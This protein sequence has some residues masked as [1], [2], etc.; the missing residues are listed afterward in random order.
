MLVRDFTPQ[1]SPLGRYAGRAMGD[2]DVGSIITTGINAASGLA[3]TIINAATKPQQTLSVGTTQPYV[4]PTGVYAPP[5][6]VLPQKKWYEDP[7]TLGAIGIGVL[8]VGALLLGGRGRRMNGY[9]GRRGYAGYGAH[10]RRRR[11]R[12]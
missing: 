1:Y 6:Q 11:S 3:T 5:Q 8:G 7:L 2:V 12:R 4:G 10:P 9:A